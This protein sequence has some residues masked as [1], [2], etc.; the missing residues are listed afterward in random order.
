[1]RYGLVVVGWACVCVMAGHGHYQDN[2]LFLR[3]NTR[4]D[5][6]THEMPIWAYFL[7][8]EECMGGGFIA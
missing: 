1:M 7:T 2:L 8:G 3:G 5:A 6:R 4:N